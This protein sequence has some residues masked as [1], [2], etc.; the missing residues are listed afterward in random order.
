M[1]CL[2]RAL[3]VGLLVCVGAARS[4]DRTSSAPAPQP[5][6]AGSAGPPLSAEDLELLKEIPLLERLELLRN[7]ELFE[8]EDAGPPKEPKG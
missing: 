4:E 1:R 6:D 8:S 3:V 2:G 5:A 7:L